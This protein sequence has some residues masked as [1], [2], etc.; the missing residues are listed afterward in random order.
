M[1][2][3]QRLIFV[4]RANFQLP[5]PPP[6][7]LPKASASYAYVWNIKMAQHMCKHQ[8]SVN[9]HSQFCIKIEWL[10]KTFYNELTMLHIFQMGNKIENWYNIC[11]FFIAMIE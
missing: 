6:P 4:I 11:S 5:P 2:Q 1:K 7:P 10:I 9:P 3:L 8:V